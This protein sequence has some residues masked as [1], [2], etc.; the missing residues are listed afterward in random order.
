[1]YARPRLFSTATA[2][3]AAP[4]VGW[5]MLWR[6]APS[7]RGGCP[8]P[9]ATHTGLRLAFDQGQNLRR[10]RKLGDIDLGEIAERCERLARAAAPTPHRHRRDSSPTRL[11]SVCTASA[12]SCGLSSTGEGPGGG[13]AAAASVGAASGGVAL[14]AGSAGAGAGAA[15]E[16]P[17]SRSDLFRARSEHRRMDPV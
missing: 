13:V 6:W 16:A 4:V 12:S 14:S 7:P 8:S 15:T 5:C 17:Y 1:M 11:S 9:E 10:W 3:I 2:V